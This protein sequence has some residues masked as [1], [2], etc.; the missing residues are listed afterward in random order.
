[1]DETLCLMNVNT[2]YVVNPVKRVGEKNP[3]QQNNAGRYVKH[4]RSF[5]CVP[6]NRTNLGETSFHQA[7]PGHPRAP[8]KPIRRCDGTFRAGSRGGARRGAG[9]VDAVELLHPGGRLIT[10]C[11]DGQPR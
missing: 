10:R 3:L 11:S 2:Y 5:K 7:N 9:A 6:F 8:R 4:S 1:M